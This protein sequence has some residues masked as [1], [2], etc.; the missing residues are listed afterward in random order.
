MNRADFSGKPPQ[1]EPPPAS[2]PVRPGP[3]TRRVPAASL[4]RLPPPLANDVLARARF[5]GIALAAWGLFVGL[6]AVGRFASYPLIVTY[7]AALAGA[8]LTVGA[9]HSATTSS[10]TEHGSLFGS[11]YFP[12]ATWLAVGATDVVSRL[13]SPGWVEALGRHTSSA[14]RSWRRPLLPAYVLIPSVIAHWPVAHRSDRPLADRYAR[15]ASF[16]N[17]PD[18]RSLIEL[19]AGGHAAADLQALVHHDRP[20][21]LVVGAAGGLALRLVS[22]A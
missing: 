3:P 18:G 4:S 22:R 14:S 13:G 20:D 21:V 9:T 16:A 11:S 6:R 5:G 2:P 8:T 1:S 15:G 10:L 7:L 19:G 12:M 17:C